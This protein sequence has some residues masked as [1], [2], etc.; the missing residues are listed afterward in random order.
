MRRMVLYRKKSILAVLLTFVLLLTMSF[1]LVNQP[2]EAVSKAEL[3]ALKK[4]QTQLAE[5]KA[6]LQKQADAIKNQVNSQTEKLTLLNAQL[7]VTASEMENLSDQIAV[8]EN[9]IA[10][11]ENTLNADAQKEQELLAQYRV[12]VRA[13]EEAGPVSYITILFQANSFA[14][15]LSRIDTIKE[16]MDH[17]NALIVDVQAAQVKV[18]Q[19]KAAMEAEMAEQQTVF[20]MY[21]EKA[22]DLAAQQNEV[23]A[24][25]A[26]LSV[27][28]AE[29]KKQIDSVAA[30]QSSIGTKISDMQYKLAEQERIKAEQA[31]ALKAAAEKKNNKWYGDA[32]SSGTGTGQDIV[33]FA[34][35]F[36]GVP[37]V[38]GGTSPKGFDCSG[39]VYYCYKN[40]GYSLNRTASGQALN[41]KSVSASELKAGDIIIFSNRGG[42]SIGHCGIYIGNGKFIHAPHTGDVVKISSLSDAYYSKHYMYARRII[43]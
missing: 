4:Q 42:K 34:K 35:S 21:Q 1:V 10:E 7:D 23:N 30:L 16:I 36:L 31:A 40:Y 20:D 8:Y 38:Y 37:Y 14:D 43:N 3:N 9:S 6:E 27:D 33:D 12:R 18:G 17:D 5:Q 2:A 24:I 22:D 41:G 19:A 39:L 29:Y 15:L 28:S 11:M 26:S 25:L 32:A 13:M